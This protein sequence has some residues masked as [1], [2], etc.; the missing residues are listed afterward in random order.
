MSYAV[1]FSSRSSL[2]ISVA[3]IAM[4]SSIIGMGGIRPVAL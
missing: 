1:P 2:K 4:V 3:L